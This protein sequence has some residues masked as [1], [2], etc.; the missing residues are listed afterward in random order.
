[1][2]AS[3]YTHTNIQRERKKEKEYNI[4]KIDRD[5]CEQFSIVFIIRQIRRHSKKT[6]T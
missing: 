3:L 4:L 6:K 2:Y 5:L 1:M